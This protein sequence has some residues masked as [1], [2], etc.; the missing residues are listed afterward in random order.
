MKTRIITQTM[1]DGEIYGMFF[2]SM[3]MIAIVNK[4]IICFII[5]NIF[6]CVYYLL[7]TW[8]TKY[9]AGVPFAKLTSGNDFL[10]YAKTDWI[11]SPCFVWM[12]ALI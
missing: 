4:I 9:H 8:C 12:A 1:K 3:T 6:M 5:L 7:I 11:D 10:A 2:S